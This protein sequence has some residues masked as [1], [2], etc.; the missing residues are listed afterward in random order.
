MLCG[1]IYN[2]LTYHVAMRHIF[3]FNETCFIVCNYVVLIQ[4]DEGHD[5]AQEVPCKNNCGMQNVVI[6]MNQKI[7][8]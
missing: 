2:K 5:V 6:I 7:S 8:C 1:C 4:Q 3:C